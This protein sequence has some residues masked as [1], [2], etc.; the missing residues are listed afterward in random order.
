MN[1]KEAVRIVKERSHRKILDINWKDKE[2]KM[3]GYWGNVE[4]YNAKDFISFAR[5][6]THEGS[7]HWMK[8]VKHYGKKK[9]RRETRDLINKEDFDNI[10]QQG[11]CKDEDVWAWD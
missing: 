11:R 7:N 5:S 4:I 2:V 1:F 10:P 3:E 6:F 8:Q 9:N